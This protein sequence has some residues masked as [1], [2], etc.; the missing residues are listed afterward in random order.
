M[1]ETTDDP[2]ALID[3]F[4]QRFGHERNLELPA[5]SADGT[6]QIQRGTAV[7]SI[8]VVVEQGVLLLLSRVMPV[9]DGQREDLFRRLLELSFLSTGDAAFAINPKTDE[10]FLRCLRRLEGLDYDEF[11]DLLH[12]IA[13]VADQWDDKL[14]SEFGG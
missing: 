5:L 1:Q 13:T 10:V 12:T 6:S 3:G 9:P 7:V 4:I 2:R 11:E 8:H 14:R